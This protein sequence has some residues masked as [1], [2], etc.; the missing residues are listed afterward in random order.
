MIERRILLHWKRLGLAYVDHLCGHKDHQ[1]GFDLVGLSASEEL[2]E[3]WQILEDRQSGHGL[4]V[5]LLDESADCKGLTVFEGN[6]V[7][8]GA[9]TRLWQSS[10]DLAHDFPA[11]KID[12]LG[13]KVEIDRSVSAEPW[14]GG[15]ANACANRTLGNRRTVLT[16]D[17]RFDVADDVANEDFVGSTIVTDHVWPRDE[18]AT[19]RD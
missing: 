12:D 9:L 15:E 5:F 11:L 6:R 19:V 4:S 13:S 10:A 2:T 1:F 18:S 17:D 16:T 14:E 3:D 7:L 8:R